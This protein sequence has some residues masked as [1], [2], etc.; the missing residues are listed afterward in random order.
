MLLNE[1]DNR[2]Q[3]DPVAGSVRGSIQRSVAIIVGIM[4]IIVGIIVITYYETPRSVSKT[5]HMISYPLPQQFKQAS[6][7][8]FCQP[9]QEDSYCALVDS[10]P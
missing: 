5:Y 1:Y 8:P 10:D 4:V 3:L 9:L 7:S 6:D 2:F